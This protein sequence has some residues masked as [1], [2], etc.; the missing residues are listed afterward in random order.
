MGADLCKLMASQGKYFHELKSIIISHVEDEA[1]IF[2]PKW[3][4]NDNDFTTFVSNFMPQPTLAPVRE[5]IATQYP[6]SAYKN[7]TFRLNALI[8]DASFTCNNWQLFQAYHSHI[9]TYMMEYN[10]TINFKG[11]NLLP[12]VHGTDLA[13]T[14][15]NDEIHF[16]KFL[17]EVAQKLDK[18]ISTLEAIGLATL[19]AEFA[20]HYQ[21]YLVSNAIYGDPNKGSFQK[22][23]WPTATTTVSAGITKVSNV[24]MA[25]FTPLPQFTTI[26]DNIIN[27]SACNFWQSVAGIVDPATAMQTPPP[28]ALWQ[29]SQKELS[30]FDELK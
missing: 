25:S 21:S 2:V 28:S 30:D 19:Y 14:F 20:P 27:V 22:H 4:S 6:A 5:A 3:V 7:V 24:Q 16:W 29:E 26:V 1:K 15:W 12:A 9:P 18:N 10:Y 23:A 17:Q 11:K 13:P 8:R